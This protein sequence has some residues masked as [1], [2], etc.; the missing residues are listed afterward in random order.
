MRFQQDFVKLT[1]QGKST[2]GGL[3]SFRVYFKVKQCKNCLKVSDWGR[4]GKKWTLTV[5]DPG[6]GPGG[7][8]ARPPLFLDQIFLRPPPLIQGLD[9]RSPLIWRSRSATATGQTI[10]VSSRAFFETLACEQA[11]HEGESRESP[12]ELHA[13]GDASSNSLGVKFLRKISKFKE[14][15]K[16][17]RHLFAFST[18][19]KLGNFTSPV[20][21][22]V[23]SCC[24]ANHL[25]ILLFSRSHR[26]RQI[27]IFYTRNNTFTHIEHPVLTPESLLTYV[28]VGFSP[29]SNLFTSAINGLKTCSHCTKVW[30]MWDL[31]FPPKR[32]QGSEVI[33]RNVVHS[34]CD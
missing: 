30:G 11:L 9:D 27:G 20:V 1:Y 10:R 3:V 16:V 13:I 23:Q 6:E 17:D 8:G 14:K 12:R 25:K 22:Y 31:I 7:P 28:S 19:V 24:F 32:T 5:A 21:Q 4:I 26:R 18:N 15:K 2:C 34:N 33:A 29:R